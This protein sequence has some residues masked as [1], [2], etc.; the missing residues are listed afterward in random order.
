MMWVLLTYNFST[1]ASRST[2]THAKYGGELSVQVRCIALN[3]PKKFRPRGKRGTPSQGGR[4]LN[5]RLRSRP[6]PT[7]IVEEEIRFRRQCIF[8]YTLFT[9]VVSSDL[10]VLSYRVAHILTVV[11]YCTVSAMGS[12][13]GSLLLHCMLWTI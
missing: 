10:Q 11:Q 2:H 7:S 1:V 5:R 3:D 4:K 9:S 8:L 13:M 6:L 12:Y